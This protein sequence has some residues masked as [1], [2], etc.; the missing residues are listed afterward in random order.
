M[1]IRRRTEWNLSKLAENSYRKPFEIHKNLKDFF[2]LGFLLGKLIKAEFWKCQKSYKRKNCYKKFRQNN[3]NYPSPLPFR[4]LNNC[5]HF[6]CFFCSFFEENVKIMIT[7]LENEGKR[8]EKQPEVNTKIMSLLS[9]VDLASFSSYLEKNCT[10]NNL[11]IEVKMHRF[12]YFHWLAAG[13]NSFSSSPIPFCE[14]SL[15]FDG[16]FIGNN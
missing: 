4:H 9:E 16:N 2:F 14:F 12:C 6:S 7:Y 5:T 10:G 13:Y 3:S 11:Q 15:F 8:R 1:Q